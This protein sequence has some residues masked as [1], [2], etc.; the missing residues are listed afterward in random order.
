MEKKTGFQGWYEGSLNGYFADGFDGLITGTDW[1]ES[2]I[3]YSIRRG[4]GRGTEEYEPLTNGLK[5]YKRYTERTKGASRVKRKLA[6]A[7]G[8]TV[9]T[10]LGGPIYAAHWATTGIRA[11][12]RKA[13]GKPI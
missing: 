11:A 6:Y 12:K 2:L 9:G 13:Q 10:M 1:V 3:E 5:R 7:T 4:K 8:V